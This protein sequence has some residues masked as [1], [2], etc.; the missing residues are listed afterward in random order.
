MRQIFS[1]TRLETVEGVAE[2]LNQHGIQ[3]RIT[4]GR[5]YKGNRR[6]RS[7]YID[8]KRGSGPRPTVWIVFPDDQPRARELL[9]DAGLLETTR[10]PYAG[11]PTPYSSRTPEPAS[12]AS[13]ARVWLVIVVVV[14]GGL[15]TLRTCYKSDAHQRAPAPAPAPAPATAPTTEPAPDD[16]S[17]IVPIDTSLIR[18]ADPT[19]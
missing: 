13:R 15:T 3:T 4:N 6:S 7:T 8:S 18:P 12:I 9:R 14:L 11:E 10:T 16:R 19:D 5:S 2:L 17:H 1:S